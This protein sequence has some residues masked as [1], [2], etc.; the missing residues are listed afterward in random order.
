MTAPRRRGAAAALAAATA[1]VLATAPAPALAASTRF[2]DEPAALSAGQHDRLLRFTGVIRAALEGSGERM[3]LVSRSGLAL[4]RFG[5]RYS[6]AGLSLRASA[7]T[8]WAVRQLY[9][10]CDERRPRLFDQGLA[11]FVQGMDRPSLGF[12]SV[13]L[14]PPDRAASLETLA[15]DNSA[16]L[17]V[18]AADYSANAYAFSARYQNCNQWV[19]ELL[20]TAWSAARSAAERADERADERAADGATPQPA[21]R[22]TDAQDWLRKAGYTPAVFDLGSRLLMW[23]STFSPWLHSDDH[24]QEDTA[25]AVYRVSMPSSLEAFVQRLAP[26]AQRLEFCHTDQHIVV[27]RGWQPLDDAC[28]AGPQD[29]VI[30]LD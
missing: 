6:H 1:A 17:A 13:V 15:L 25:K 14:L 30:A 28:L 8:P 27:R 16:A 20:A 4:G 21:A 9:F 19:A 29:T 2:C 11:A 10:A 23:L 5:Q 18:L 24:P 22:R 12:V 7:E 26:T 3:A